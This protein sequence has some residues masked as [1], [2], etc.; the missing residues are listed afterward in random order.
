M[1][2]EKSKDDVYRAF[3]AI[4]QM[5]A[6]RW[7]EADVLSL[8]ITAEARNP[9]MRSSGGEWLGCRRGRIEATGVCEMAL[10]YGTNFRAKPGDNV[11]EE[12][13]AIM[14]DSVV[15]TSGHAIIGFTLLVSD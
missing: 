1:A 7:K 2:K 11:G 15:L 8:E 14:V 4:D 5:F 9:L 12:N 10:G 6:A 13:I 3:A